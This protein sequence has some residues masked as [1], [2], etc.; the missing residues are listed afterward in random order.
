MSGGFFRGQPCAICGR[1]VP[2]HRVLCLTCA[3]PGEPKPAEA[4]EAWAWFH[5]RREERRAS[6]T[7]SETEQS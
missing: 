5:R 1:I 3:K 4:G 2:Q 7:D 6:P